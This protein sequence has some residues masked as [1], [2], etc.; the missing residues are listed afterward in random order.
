M[1]MG[2]VN[3]GQEAEQ[4]KNLIEARLYTNSKQIWAVAQSIKPLT[5]HSKVAIP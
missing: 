1:Y 2:S 4:G 5:S 3:L